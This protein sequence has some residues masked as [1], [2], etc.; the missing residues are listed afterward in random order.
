MVVILIG[1]N[2]VKSFLLQVTPND[3][4]CYSLVGGGVEEVEGGGGGGEFADFSY[5]WIDYSL[6][7]D[8]IN[9]MSWKLGKWVLFL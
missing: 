1:K 2:L 6:Y 9:G 3:E 5:P 7:F 4:K 8:D